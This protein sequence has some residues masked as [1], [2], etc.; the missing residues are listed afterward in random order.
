MKCMLF[1]VGTFHVFAHSH[2]WGNFD[3]GVGPATGQGV[4]TVV[5]DA[6]GV[7]ARGPSVLDWSDVDIED[8]RMCFP[9]V[10]DWKSRKVQ[11]NR[12]ERRK[13]VSLLKGD[14][15]GLQWRKRVVDGHPR[16]R[17]GSRTTDLPRRRFQDRVQ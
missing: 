11:Q 7:R 14:T 6:G 1:G 8:P 9:N 15:T 2:W 5:S 4:S 13:G 10:C 17:R 16:T 3:G 12:R